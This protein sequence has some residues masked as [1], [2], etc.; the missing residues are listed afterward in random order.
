[1]VKES[2]RVLVFAL[3]LSGSAA[4][5][6]MSSNPTAQ[7]L[8][9]PGPPQP[10][11]APPPIAAAPPQADRPAATEANPENEKPK[12][13]WHDTWLIVDNSVTAQTIGVG[14]SFQSS[15]PTY[16]LSAS[17][18]PRFYFYES[19]VEAFL[20]SGRIDVA[21][22]FTNNDVT[23]ER[24]EVIVGGAPHGVGASDPTLFPAYRRT[25]AKR[26]DYETLLI[27][28]AP[29]L[30]FPL[31]KFSRSNGTILGL[32][33]EVRFYQDLPLAGS[34]SSVFKK[35]TLGAIAGYNHTFT[36]ATTPTNPELRRYRM[37]P[38]GRT[39]PGDQLTGAAFPQHE[40]Q[41]TLRFMVEVAKDVSWWTDF[42]Y[43]PTWLYPIPETNIRTL[44]GPAVPTG[45][46][47]PTTFVTVTGFVTSLYYHVMNELT[48]GV[49]YANIETQP[50][51]D[52]QRRNIFYSPGALFTLE[53]IGHLDEMYLTATGRR[54]TETS[55]R[56]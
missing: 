47:N 19:D 40:L 2:A 22:E 52:G 46:A 17:L 41:T 12:L 31:S 43:E 3:A 55:L 56:R 8:G 24:G 34:R 25:L 27:G 10:A 9:Q 35:L 5:D 30:T 18:R 54:S 49:E 28:Y 32:G 26:G 14:S 7:P 53:L 48:L 38:E 51:L 44:T 1:M 50:G 39:V 11:A 36:Q 29:V 33:A 6:E 42:M 16:D 45:V 21:R 15:N 23:T 37:D 13:P 20:L 4:A